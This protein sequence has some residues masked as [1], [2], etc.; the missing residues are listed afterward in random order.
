MRHKI[1]CLFFIGQIFSGSY[2]LGQ[3]H[4]GVTEVDCFYLD[5]QGKKSGYKS[6]KVFL[7]PDRIEWYKN[8]T[9][10]GDLPHTKVATATYYQSDTDSKHKVRIVLATDHATGGSL[11]KRG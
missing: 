4:C 9:K 8:T 10:K 3:K 1:L 7:R 2:A 5:K 11:R 6:R